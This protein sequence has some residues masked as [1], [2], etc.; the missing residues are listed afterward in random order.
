[1]NYQKLHD[2][3]IESAKNRVHIKGVHHK[4]HIIPLHEDPNSTE[5]V[6][7]TTKE[8]KI[9]HLLRYK[10]NGSVGNLCAYYLLSGT[11]FNISSAAGKIEGKLTFRRLGSCVNLN[12]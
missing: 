9:V 11:C 3:I 6:S 4:H 7:L 5:T 2:S 12:I 10:I 1:M 8:H